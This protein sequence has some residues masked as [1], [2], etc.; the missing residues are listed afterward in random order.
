M[1]A[2][3]ERRFRAMG[4]DARVVVVGGSPLIADAAARRIDE[5]EHR[6]SRFLPTSEISQLNRAEGDPVVVSADT[7]TLAEHLVR[8]WRDTAGLFDP[9]LHDSLVALGYDD[10]WPF[11]PPTPAGDPL[12]GPGCDGV[13]LD[14]VTR[15]VWMPEGLHLDPGGLGK[16][17]AADLVAGEVMAAGARGV[18][19]DIGGDLRVIG[20]SPEGPTWRI[21]VEHPG[22]PEVE[23][24]RVETRDGGVAT[25]SRRKRRWKLPDGREA[26]HVLDPFDGRPAEVRW[27]SATA[28]AKRA[29]DA[30]VGATVAF[31]D[32]R[33]DAAPRVIA[34]LLADAEGG[35][36]VLGDH[37]ELFLV[38]NGVAA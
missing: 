34:A 18:L 4:S 11:E 23:L 5:L 24:A 8:A 22:A 9:T 12:P 35:T 19:V 13:L 37:P 15:M 31:L 36:T 3:Q 20:D 10:T 17:L 32:H 25:T 28:L 7:F 21:A 33:L 26:H 29:V 1:A 30:E 16:G 27:T 38:A 14:R 2:A 6:W